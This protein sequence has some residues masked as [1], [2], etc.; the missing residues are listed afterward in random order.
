MLAYDRTRTRVRIHRV[1]AAVY[2]RCGEV[3]SLFMYLLLSMF[4]LLA[5]NV[6]GHG[7]PLSK[8]RHGSDKVM[9][10]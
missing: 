5:M 10:W 3:F 1:G 9:D 6:R 4:M 2:F 8:S 7:I